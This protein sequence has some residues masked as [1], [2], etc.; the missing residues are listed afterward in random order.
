[1]L[2]GLFLFFVSVRRRGDVSGA[3]MRFLGINWVGVNPENGQKLLLSLA[4]IAIVVVVSRILRWLV[5]VVLRRTDTSGLQTKFWTRQ[6]ISLLSAIVLI[7][8]LL[9]IWFSDPQAVKE[10]SRHNRRRRLRDLLKPVRPTLPND[11]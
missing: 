5:G 2:S 7:L 6:G 8:G 1:M 9:S 11:G 10:A 4:F 3:K